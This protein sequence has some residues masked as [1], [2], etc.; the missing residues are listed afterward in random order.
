MGLDWGVDKCT[1]KL[2]DRHADIQDEIQA[3]KQ[4]RRAVSELVCGPTEGHGALGLGR[5]ELAVCPN[6]G[7]GPWGTKGLMGGGTEAETDLL[8]LWLTLVECSGGVSERETDLGID[9][10][11]ISS[12]MADKGSGGW[13][14]GTADED[15]G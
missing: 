2:A 4:T 12:E 15:T 5:G 1:S 9:D 7:P 13:S 8:G 6:W 11:G 14:A 3:D 10:K